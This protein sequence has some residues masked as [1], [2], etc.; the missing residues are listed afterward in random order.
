MS[1]YQLRIHV[2]KPGATF[3]DP[4]SGQ[5]HPSSE[6]HV[7]YEVI[8][9]DGTTMVQAG[10]APVDQKTTV[11]SVLGEVKS[12]DGSAYAGDSYFTAT[13]NITAAQAETLGKYADSPTQYGFSLTYWAGSNSCVDYVWKGLNVIGM[14]PSDYE[15]ALL[16]IDNVTRFSGLSNSSFA[17]N[18]L[19]NLEKATNS[20]GNSFVSGFTSKQ[21]STDGINW[22]N[23][24]YSFDNASAATN[25][26]HAAWDAMANGSLSKTGF[27]NV[28]NSSTSFL[29]NNNTTTY[30]PPT[31]NGIYDPIGAFYE[32][33]SAG[34]DPALTISNKTFRV[35]NSAGAGLTAAQVAALDTNA[36]GKVS[37][38]ELNGLYAW[39]DSNEDGVGQTTELTTLA[40]ALANAGLSGIRASDYS[41]YTSGNA[42]YRTP[43]QNTAL[44]PE[45]VN[46]LQTVPASN[47][48][49]LRAMDNVYWVNSSMY[50]A[51]GAGQVKI[52]N[53]NRTYLIG[54]DGN[55]NFDANY[56]AS[57]S[58][59]FNNSLLVNFLAGAG[60]DVMGGST[61]NDNLWGGTGNDVLFGYAGDDKLYGEEG[62]DELQGGVGNDYLDG[63]VDNDKLFGQV[64]NDV[65]VGGVGDDILVGFTA[66]NDA[67][68]TLAAGETDNDTL[69]GGAGNDQM[70][71]GLGNDYMDGGDGNDFL[72]GGDDQDTMYG[73]AGDDELSAGTGNDVMDGGVGAD[74]LFGGVGN[75]QMWGG[76]GNDIMVGFT[77]SNE[78]K[79][80]LNAGETDNDTMYG[81]AGDDLMLGGLGDDQV[82]GGVG[83]DEIQGQDGNDQLYGEDGNDRLFGG[84]GND[85]IYGGNGD[86]TIIGGVASNEI[87]LAAGVS[88]SNFLYGGAG[89]DTIVSGVGNDYIDGG[90]GADN[91]QGGKG[92]DTY[93]VNSVNDVILEQQNEGYDTVISSSNYIL[94]ANIEELRLVE[95]FNI[96]GTGNSLNNKII[97]NSQDNILD[98]V[99]G[100]D[101]MI[102]G[103]G[104]DTYY[105]DNMGDQ[106]V[107]LAGEGTDTINTSISYALGANVENLTLLD[108]SKAEKGIADGVNI[109]VYG[110]PKAFEL[111]Y[112]QG[113]AVAGYKGTCALTSIANLAT[114]AKQSVSEAQV[115]QTA[116][117]NSWCVSSSTATE[118]QRG[119]SNYI[120]QQALL[121]SYGIRNGIVM[122]YNEQAIANL[123]KGGR[124]VVIAVNAGKL[125]GDSAYVEAGGVNHVVTVT[126]VACDATTGSINGFY[127]ADSGRGLVSDMTRYISIADFRTDANVANA[128]S[129]YTID[130]I[131][132]WEENINATGN[133]LANQITGNR[134]NNILDGAA[135]NDTLVG[136]AGNDT[137][138]FGRGTGQDIVIDTDSTAGN[139][140]VISVGAGVANDQ[141]WFR[142]VGNDLEISIIG[143]TDKD[144]IQNWYLGSQNQIEQIKT[145]NG[146]VLANTDVDK[147]VQAM[148]A[149]TPP[150]S[151]TSTL[152]ASYQ[153]TLAPVIAA[154]WH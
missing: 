132:L 69:Y 112:M 41:F 47:Y 42:N 29:V 85:T 134:G 70:Y 84:A 9:P 141:L 113:N 63:G 126:G 66:S 82:L 153:T 123:I 6:G 62:S 38:V 135:G 74:K 107:E 100:A 1:N 140:D 149:L 129:I 31:D 127:I 27:E 76:D 144:V 58:Q 137:Y 89:N 154:N 75:D 2:E 13:Y 103:L 79:Q 8:K 92:D 106:V 148:A 121:N 10:F 99:T 124:G 73:V 114:Q 39:S 147:L 131:K 40:T 115:V 55:D 23:S 4:Q 105:V 60:N 91:M 128:Y 78:T 68:Q 7:W 19:V 43:A 143:T 25:A 37:G 59:Y 86:D 110:Y 116:I 15:G 146:K 104:N 72:S 88:D 136:Q 36:D 109:L 57:Y 98:G 122:G 151:G 101:T 30:T 49:L 17:N 139:T 81:G 32:S 3:T 18:G 44:A 21:T 54:T 48:T 111:D 120:G 71:G 65:L 90:A 80:T 53:S 97:G 108:F 93:V 12:T 56:Y 77:A 125:W 133:A 118:Y 119:G 117:N 138:V 61:R 5:I 142:H 52:N 33:R 95:G 14:N 24:T 96:N 152:S 150:A 46:V 145:S 64:G 20:I 50:I 87:A 28:V 35:L 94:N 130:P 83:A 45:Q 67:K 51:F 16:P 34:N 26:D 11:A 22:S 102:G